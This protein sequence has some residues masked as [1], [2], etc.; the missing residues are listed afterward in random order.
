MIAV[1]SFWGGLDNDRTEGRL[2][3]GRFSAVFSYN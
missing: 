1:M 2:L 3:V